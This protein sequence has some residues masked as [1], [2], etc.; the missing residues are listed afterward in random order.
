M[1]AEEEKGGTTLKTVTTR[2]KTNLS[3]ENRVKKPQLEA[4][5]E[6][7]LTGSGL[8]KEHNRAADCPA[9]CLTYTQSTSRESLSWMSDKLES[10]LPG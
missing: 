6:Q 5:R 10:R 2:N 4:C 3:P 9:V 8:R 7:Q 1:L